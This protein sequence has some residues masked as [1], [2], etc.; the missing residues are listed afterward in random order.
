MTEKFDDLKNQFIVD[1]AEYPKEKLSKM[2][3]IMLKF[4]KVSKDGQVVLMQ[5]IPTRK[6]L[7]LILSARFVANKIDKSIKQEVGRDELFTY[8]YLKKEVFTARFNE[9]V[10]DGFAEKKDDHV[11]AKNIL[12]VERFLEKLGDTE[13]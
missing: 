6:V 4:V 9:L 13:K 1:T 10:R 3:Q 2:M 5:D 8:S 7:Y 12:L 11:Q